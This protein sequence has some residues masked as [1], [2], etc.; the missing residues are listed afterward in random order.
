MV[1]H[2]GKKE[3]TTP[4]LRAHHCGISVP[5]LEEGIRWYREMLG[6][7]VKGR[8]KLE[9]AKAKIA[10]LTNGEFQ[11]ELF[12]VAGAAPLPDESRF[13]DS[14]LRTHGTK[15]IAFAV[16]DLPSFMG[17]LK[18]RGVDVAM[19]VRTM[20]DGKVAFIR[21]NAGTLIELLEPL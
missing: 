7:A 6:F 9:A 1:T 3:T 15:H 21:D 14:D 2:E 8:T 19:D 18:S 20:P 13:P 11:I 17:M 12:E 10:F 5:N 4:S 16:A